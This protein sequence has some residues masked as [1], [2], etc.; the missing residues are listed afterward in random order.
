MT[1][2]ERE[3]ALAGIRGVWDWNG[4]GGALQAV[5]QIAFS[6]WSSGVKLCVDV[7]MSWPL[8]RG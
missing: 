6:S 8:I 2:A 3:P 4:E 7:C 1:S 5:C